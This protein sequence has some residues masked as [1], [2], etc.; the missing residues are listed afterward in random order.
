MTAPSPPRLRANDSAPD[1]LFATVEGVPASRSWWLAIQATMAARANMPKVSGA[2]AASL[3]PYWGEGFFGVGWSAPYVWFQERGTRAHTMRS[4]A[5][6]TIPMWVDDPDGSEHRKNPRS[7][8]RIT[9]D[10]RRQV[11]IF[12]HAAKIGQRKLVRR[13]VA[14][15]SVLTSVP[16]SYPGAP[17]RIALREQ[18]GG[19]IALGNVGVRWRHPGL[20]A[21]GF[22][23]AAIARVAFSA[24]L[25][26]PRITPTRRET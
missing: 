9:R 25:G 22:V 7:K 10:G 17:G 23:Y 5:G 1:A 21:G 16:A 8:V 19:R 15:Q 6:K 2:A 26:H 24:G 3:Q 11:L 13:R 20:T 18:V 12:R 14:G 4:L